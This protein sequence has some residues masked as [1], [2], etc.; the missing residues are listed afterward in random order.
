MA[1]N[2]PP[3]LL[4]A[5]ERDVKNAYDWYDEQKPGLGDVFLGRVE[6]CLE[7]IQRSPNAFQPVGPD[8]RRAVVKQFPYVIFYRF[9]GKVMFVYAVFHTAQDPKIWMERLEDEG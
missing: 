8:A 9:V 1:K 2:K 5:A 7:A 6:E 3:V 4:P